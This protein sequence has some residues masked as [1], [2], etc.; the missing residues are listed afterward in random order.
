MPLQPIAIKTWIKKR[1]W[2]GLYLAFKN[3][4]NPWNELPIRKHDWNSS[5]GN[6]EKRH[7]AALASEP[8]TAAK[9]GPLSAWQPAL[10]IKLLT[11]SPS[12]EDRQNPLLPNQTE[13]IIWFSRKAFTS[14]F[15]ASHRSNVIP[16]TCFRERQ[17]KSFLRSFFCN[18]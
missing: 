16:L 10:L 8:V 6:T 9:H 11:I 1:F 3:R 17:V 4:W 18:K 5:S 7:S 14:N 13:E 15:A 12:R 2:L